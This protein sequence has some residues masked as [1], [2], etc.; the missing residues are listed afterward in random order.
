DLDPEQ[1]DYLSGRP[2]FHIGAKISDEGSGI[3][4]S[5]LRLELDGRNIPRYAPGEEVSGKEGFLFELDTYTLDYTTHETE[6]RSTALR[7]GHHTATITVRDWKGNQAVKSWLFTVDD[8]IPRRAR[9]PVNQ[10]GGPGGPGGYPGG[11][12]GNSGANSGGKG[13]RIGD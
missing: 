13:G 3:D 6:G 8:T 2:P 11:E 9:R 12:G 1:G 7:D 5:T 10:P 4:L